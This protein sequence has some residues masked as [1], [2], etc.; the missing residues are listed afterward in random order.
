MSYHIVSF[1]LNQNLYTAT[2]IT[3]EKR[4]QHNNL[5]HK[6]FTLKDKKKTIDI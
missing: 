4:E 3:Q 1:L 2:H 5:K 6:V